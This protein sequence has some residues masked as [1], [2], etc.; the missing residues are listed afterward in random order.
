MSGRLQRHHT[1]PEHGFVADID[2]V[3]AHECQLA[4]IADA[5]HRQACGYCLYRVTIT[6]ID[7]K[8]VLRDQQAATRVDVKGARVDLLGLDV[9][10]Q[11][12]LAGR[13]VDRIS[14]DAVFATFE[15]LL[16]LKLDC[17]LARFAPYR[18]RPFGWTWTVPAA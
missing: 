9:L 14:D 6:H 7:R 18:K 15:D 16:T 3:F 11:G 10:D 8:I 5:E 4:I 2:V 1:H 17:R 12:R 13:L